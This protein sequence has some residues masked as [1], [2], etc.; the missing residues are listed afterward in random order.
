[1]TAGK[2]VRDLAVGEHDCAGAEAGD[3]PRGVILEKSSRRHDLVRRV[4]DPRVIEPDC[5]RGVLGL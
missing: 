4:C 3:R 2:R 1:M 5:Y